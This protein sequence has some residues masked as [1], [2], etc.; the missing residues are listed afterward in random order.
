MAELGRVLK[1]WRARQDEAETLA[2]KDLPGALRLFGEHLV[3]LASRARELA[4]TIIENESKRSEEVRAA[5]QAGTAAMSMLIGGSALVGTVLALAISIVLT[6]RLTAPL[7][8]V[9]AQARTVASGGLYQGPLKR[10]T[11]DEVGDLVEAV[12]AMSA[13]LRDTIIELASHSEQVIE[14]MNQIVAGTDEVSASLQ[15]QSA[16]VR[17]ISSA[18]EEMSSSVTEVAHKSA[19]VATSAEQSGQRAREGGAV[20]EQTVAD[21]REIDQAVSSSATIVTDLGQRSEQIG[22]IVGVINDIAEQTNL[23]ALNAAIEAARAGE[24]GRGFAVVADEVRK[25]ADRTTKATEEITESIKAIRVETERAVTQIGSGVERVKTGGERAAQAGTNLK[26][27]VSD[28]SNVASM[29][30]SI[31]AAAE[32]QAAAAEEISRTITGV[33]ESSQTATDSAGNAAKIAASLAKGTERLK[34]IVERFTTE[35]RHENR[36]AP[37]G[38]GERRARSNAGERSDNASSAQRSASR[39]QPKL[40]SRPAPQTA[41]K[42]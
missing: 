10:T 2:R 36:G 15:R 20:V 14:G 6:R 25:L 4:S 19:D 16:Q 34:Q 31:A 9:V 5:L 11:N 42:H 17:E 38:T 33:A 18:V 22:S 40:A 24:H 41:G 12:N 3:P 21:M 7:Q 27:I 13:S 1:D 35:R 8:A 37:V 30:Q 23:L 28:A 26:Q 29:V 32:Q 39:A